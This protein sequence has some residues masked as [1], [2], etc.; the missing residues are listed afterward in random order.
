M[1]SP[2]FGQAFY[3]SNHILATRV[4]QSANDLASTLC[5]WRWGLGKERPRYGALISSPRIVMQNASEGM[6]DFG[7]ICQSPNK[8]FFDARVD[9]VVECS[10]TLD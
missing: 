7:V 1:G 9:V 4:G 6:E 3:L 2:I 8:V 5:H 10:S